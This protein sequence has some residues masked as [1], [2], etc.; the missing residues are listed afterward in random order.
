MKKDVN[1]RGDVLIFVSGLKE[2]NTIINA[3]GDVFHSIFSS[4]RSTPLRRV[5][6]YFFDFIQPFKAP[7]SSSFSIP[8]RLFFVLFRVSIAG[9]SQVHRIN[10]HRRDFCDDS[11]RSLCDRQRK[12]ASI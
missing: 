12:S 7:N 9:R 3:F 10:E 5:V 8:L 2:I 4:Y 1:E 11:E 6:G